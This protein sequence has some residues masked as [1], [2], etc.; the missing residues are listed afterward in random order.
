MNRLIVVFAYANSIV[1]ILAE[2][3]AFVPS[4]FDD[5]VTFIL[6]RNFFAGYWLGYLE[7]RYLSFPVDSTG[8]FANVLNLAANVLLLIGAMQFSST[9][10]RDTWM[11]R[12][13]L[14]VLLICSLTGI[15]DVAIYSES[16]L[17]G[18]PNVLKCAALAFGSWVFLREIA[19]TRSVYII[20]ETS[21]GDYSTVSASK[22]LR[23]VNWLIDTVTVVLVMSPLVVVGEF[24]RSLQQ[25][26]GPGVAT[27][28]F[29]LVTRLVYYLF[30]ET[31][32]RATPGKFLTETKVMD[33]DDVEA[34]TSA[35]IRRTLARFIPFDAISFFGRRGW[36]DSLSYTKVVMDGS[37]ITP[38]IVA[39]PN[40]I[41]QME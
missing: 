28:S 33:D 14:A 9:N 1:G 36:H 41:D 6:I 27:I 32:F 19:T 37:T 31:F 21:S 30:F 13:L 38:P 26:F 2:L 34:S 23:A 11:I 4:P 7:P 17:I 3:A 18:I 35:I 29:M 40:V 8:Q 15:I 20:R 24:F 12:C 39:H 5:K 10:G 22:T 25:N 16:L